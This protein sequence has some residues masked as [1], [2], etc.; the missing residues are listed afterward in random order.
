MGR[1]GSGKSTLMKIVFGSL[2]TTFKSIRV[3][4]KPL[5]GNYIETGIIGYL[6]QGHYIP[7]HL[8]VKQ[9]LDFF[10]IPYDL[11]LQEFSGFS[12]M[13]DTTVRN[14]SGGYSRLL[15]AFLIL[16]SN[17]KFILLDE[18]FSGLMPQHIECLKKIMVEEKHKK[19]FWFQ[20]IYTSTLWN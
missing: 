14:L 19:G 13:M 4:G 9:A 7:S 10:K 12:I 16:K 15:E 6:R 18:P 20:I 1:N 3:D 5:V 2:E 8:K 17:H 11:L